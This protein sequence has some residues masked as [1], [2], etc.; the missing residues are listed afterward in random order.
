[1]RQRQGRE[2]LL[3]RAAR[4]I[5]GGAPA[6]KVCREIGTNQS[7]LAEWCMRHSPESVRLAARI[8]SL[9]DENGCLRVSVDDMRCHRQMLIDAFNFVFP[10]LSPANRQPS[11]HAEATSEP[12]LSGAPDAD[13]GYLM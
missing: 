2:R 11:R 3:A 1:M 9:E 5:A 6:W 12:N 4:R 10:P 8:V 13:S 7:E